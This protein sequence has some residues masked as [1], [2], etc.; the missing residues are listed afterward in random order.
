LEAMNFIER[1]LI[2]FD[3]KIAPAPPKELIRCTDVR[4]ILLWASGVGQVSNELRVWSC[5][6]LRV[7]HTIAHIEGTQR[8]ISV[9][10]ASEQVQRRFQPYLRHDPSGRLLFGDH[11]D[12]VELDRLEWKIGKSRESTILKLLHKRANVAE[13][14]FDMIGV[15]IVTKRLCDVLM[16][17]KYLRKFHMITFANCVPGRTR[18]TLIDVESFK[19]GVRKLRKLLRN[20]RIEPEQ[21]INLLEQ[22]SIPPEYEYDHA[23]N[24]HTAATYRAIQLTCRQLIRARN[25]NLV[26]LDRVEEYL[27]EHKSEELSKVV[28]FIKTWPGVDSN[29]EVAAFFPFEVQVMDKLAHEA[30]QKGEAS[31]DRYKQKQIRAAR[32]RVLGEVLGLANLALSESSDS[33]DT[34]SGQE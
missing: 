34:S 18:N 12:Y 32:R 14:I 19:Q 26:W 13:T 24:P 23:G 1:F 6:L 21:F 30:N 22:A 31:H 16:V 15:R 27:E 8:R 20:G 9:R 5:A 3:G 33:S 17:I 25:P 29:R 10:L 11:K 4:Y 2:P 28:E 7:V